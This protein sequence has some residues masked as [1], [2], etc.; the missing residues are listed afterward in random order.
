MG[1]FIGFINFKTAIHSAAC[2]ISC[3]HVNRSARCLGI[4]KLTF[5]GVNPW[6]RMVRSWDKFATID[7][8]EHPGF[9]V[10]N[11]IISSFSRSKR[12]FFWEPL[13]VFLEHKRKCLR[14][15]LSNKWKFLFHCDRLYG[16]PIGRSQFL[17]FPISNDWSD[18]IQGP[19]IP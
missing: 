17:G 2:T 8:A 4:K 12:A 7:W 16:L 3:H 9:A 11:R 18:F 14:L 5:R 13:P 15:R 19:C 6:F 10:T 1:L